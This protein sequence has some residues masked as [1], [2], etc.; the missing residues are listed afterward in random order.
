MGRPKEIED[1]VRVSTVIS[2]KQHEWIQHM[3]IS[4]SKQERRQIGVSEAIR[5]ALD[6]AYR[7]PKDLQMDLF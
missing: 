2:R 6:A 4:M 7:P 3:C 1:G 5:M